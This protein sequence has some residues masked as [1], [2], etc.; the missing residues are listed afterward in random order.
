MSSCCVYWDIG[1]IIKRVQ[2][3]LR[4]YRLGMFL[5][6]GIPCRLED[7]KPNDTIVLRIIEGKAEAGTSKPRR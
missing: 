2:T 5:R 7:T 1:F 4:F 3:C 6:G